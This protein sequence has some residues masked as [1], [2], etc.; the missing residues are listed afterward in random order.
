[1]QSAR[2]ECARIVQRYDGSM[3]KPVGDGFLACFGFPRAHEDDA[4]RAAHAGL[5]IVE[6]MKQIKSLPEVQYSARVGIATGLVVV[7]DQG[8]DETGDAKLAVGETPNMAARVQALAEPNSVAI[9]QS[10]R[11]LLGGVFELGEL[12]EHTLK[13]IS[14]RTM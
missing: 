13:G 2:D 5:N 3:M 9:A 1:M 7:G 11:R 8:D 14:G 10:T 4:A 6:S 12:G